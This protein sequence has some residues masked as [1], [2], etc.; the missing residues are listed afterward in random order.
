MK[1]LV[2]D[3]HRA[4]AYLFGE[5]LEGSGHEVRVAYSPVAALDVLEGGFVP[6]ILLSDIHMP[7]MSG[8]EL[9]SVVEERVPGIKIVLM[10][11]DF[12][13]PMEMKAGWLFFSKTIPQEMMEK[14]GI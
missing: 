8:I 7:M 13:P 6:E 2:V 14:I 10:S 1:I 4:L 5:V 11:G 3:D 12:D 9:A